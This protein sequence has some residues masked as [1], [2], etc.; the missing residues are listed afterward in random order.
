MAKNYYNIYSMTII[1]F[2]VFCTF[3]CDPTTGTGYIVDCD[4]IK[5]DLI[6]LG[7]RQCDPITPALIRQNSF[8]LNVLDKQT[9]EPLEDITIKVVDNFI[10]MIPIKECLECYIRISPWSFLGE[11]YTATTDAS[12][13]YDN[14]TDFRKYA[15]THEINVVTFRI[16]DKKGKY[17]PQ[18]AYINFPYDVS[19]GEI[20]VYLLNKE[21]L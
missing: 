9:G 8:I 17:E 5:A 21:L 11:T 16:T 1:V 3:S 18:V 7:Y 14:K 19:H 2:F 6:E 10:E 15:D 13:K 20:T 12:G 4:K